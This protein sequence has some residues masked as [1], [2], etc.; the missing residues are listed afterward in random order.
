MLYVSARFEVLRVRVSGF[1]DEASVREPMYGKVHV[2]MASVFLLFFHSTSGSE[3]TIRAI[4][5]TV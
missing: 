3:G 1:N 4:G 5:Y 2:G